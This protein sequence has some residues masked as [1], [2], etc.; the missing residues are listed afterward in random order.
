LDIALPRSFQIRRRMGRAVS[1]DYQQSNNAMAFFNQSFL[2]LRHI[3]FQEGEEQWPGKQKWSD[4]SPKP[5]NYSLEIVVISFCFI[6]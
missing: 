1:G 6:E 3:C 5:A 4:E 2:V